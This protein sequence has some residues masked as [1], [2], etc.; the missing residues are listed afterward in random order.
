M[1]TANNQV[2]HTT[3]AEHMFRFAAARNRA[4]G[5]E[6]MMMARPANW[7]AGRLLYIDGE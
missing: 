7:L 5:I 3:F 6:I 2:A 1:A 4:N